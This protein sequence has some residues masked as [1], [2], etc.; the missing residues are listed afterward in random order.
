MRM[1]L[2]TYTY[3]RPIV[4]RIYKNLLMALLTIA[5]MRRDP[6]L[7]SLGTPLFVKTNLFKQ[8]VMFPLFYLT[9]TDWNRI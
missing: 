1:T 4:L 2:R 5:L 7:D 9:G 3:Q 6:V 8:D